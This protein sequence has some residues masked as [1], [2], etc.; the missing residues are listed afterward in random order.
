MQKL[1]PIQLEL[2]IQ[3]AYHSV[4]LVANSAKQLQI[5]NTMITGYAQVLSL[6]PTSNLLPQ[7]LKSARHINV[8]MQS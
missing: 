1:K 3:Y 6:L 7:D 2:E 4:E 8:Q 5:V